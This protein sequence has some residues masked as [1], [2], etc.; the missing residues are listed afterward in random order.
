TANAAQ[1]TVGDALF[2]MAEHRVPLPPG[3]LPKLRLTDQLRELSPEEAARSYPVQLSGVI[4]WTRPD[5]EFF[6]VRDVSGGICV[7]HPPG[8]TQSLAVGRK[9]ELTGV[10]AS[11]RFTPVVYASAVQ[12]LGTIDLPEARVITLEQALT[13][14]EEAQWVTMSGYV[15]AAE[16]DGRWM[17]LDLTTFGGEF[18]AML[19]PNAQW[20][21]LPGAV[22]RLRGVCGA[23]ANEKRQLTGIQLWV[24]SSRFVEIEEAVPEDP[25]AVERRSIASLRQF[26]T[27]QV[28]NR[29]V[30]VA[31]VVVHHEPGRLVNIQGGN[32]GLLVLSRDTQPL[33]PGDRIEAVGFPG[34]ENSRAVLREAVYRRIESG[35]EPEPVVVDDIGVIDVEL[36]GRLVRVEGLLLDV[37]ARE[38]EVELINQQGG[39]VF[40]AQLRLP[41][42]DA[43]VRWEPGSK[44]VL[45]GVYEVSYD[46]Y[47]RPH[48]VRLKLRTPDDVAVLRQP[49]WWTV[50]K[51]LALTGVLGVAVVLGF[52]WV[53]ALRRRVREQT[54]VIRERLENERAA[55][56]EAALARASKLE[57]LGVLAG[58]IAHDFNNLLT[59]ILGNVSLAKMDARIDSDTVHCLNESERAAQRARDLTQQLLTFAKGGEPMRAATRLPDIVRE[60]AQFAL[61]GSNVRSEFEIASDLWPAD[62]DR[63]QIGQ[64]V[65]NIVI[66]ANQAMPAGGLVRI[67]LQN[68]EVGE[69]RS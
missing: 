18:H 33:Q 43:E 44:L 9:V 37:G 3:G 6:F 10:S 67:A 30:R 69:A 66:N 47:R 57:S 48:E 51:V 65:H 31:G 24:A 13:G 40:R 16:R 53:L 62:V 12:P 2:R 23:I 52:G 27:L 35:A 22:V 15:R 11:G 41:D 25:F 38:R 14:V 21:S 32:E 4:T 45:T 55:R 17:R 60:A 42:G 29:R 46:E 63:G 49:S 68:E 54:S 50:K 61:H 26:G 1:T 39:V 36:D 5:A 64:V 19:P 34:R 56:L 59:V 58:G 7:Y 8:M 20:A 28:L